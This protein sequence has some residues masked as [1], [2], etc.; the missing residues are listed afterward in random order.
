MNIIALKNLIKEVLNEAMEWKTIPDEDKQKA[1]DMLDT[2]NN[3]VKQSNLEYWIQ[4]TGKY[5]A[6]YTLWLY[7]TNIDSR[8]AAYIKNP[9]YMGNLTTDLL[10]SVSKAISKPGASTIRIELAADET[11]NN[12]IGKST[13]ENPLFKFGKY[14]GRAM[15]EVF[16]EDPGYFAFLAKNMDPKYADTKDNLAIKHFAIMYL[17][18]V[19][20]QNQQTS[21]SQFVGNVGERFQ[22]ELQVYKFEKKTATYDMLEYTV[23][24]LK[25]ANDNK[26]I[27]YGLDKNFPDIKE[28][29]KIN[30][31]GKIKA[32]R[33]IVGIKFTILNYVKPA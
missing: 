21:T 9:T 5:Q 27:I 3:T 28:G 31:K 30:L 33:E 29:D 18:D 10:S 14:R 19:A 15:G 23:A 4:V 32:H 12:L 25:D 2:H 17:Q 22:G 1:Y 7:K 16:L 20:K 6:Y 24:K 8:V 11:R 26:F 13:K